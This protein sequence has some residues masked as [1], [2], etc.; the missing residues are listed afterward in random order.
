MKKRLL[1]YATSFF[2]GMSVM[3]VELSI[4]RLL[5]PYFGTSQIIWTVIIGLIMISLSIGNVIGGISADKHNSMNRLYTIIWAA[6]IWIAVI[7]F[8][9]KYIIVGVMGVLALFFPSNLLISG[10]ALSCLIL[11]SIPMIGLGM[12]SP[13]LVKL[14]VNDIENTGKTAGKI[15]AMNT[16]GSIIGTFLPT[17]VTIPYIGTHKTF[18]IFSLVLNFICLTYFVFVK[19]KIIRASGTTIIVFAILLLPVSNS[20]AFWTECVV[21]DES[22]YNYLQVTEDKDS[23]YLSTNV[24]FGVQSIY[25]KDNKLSGLYYDYALM[26]PQ[27]IRNFDSENKLDLLILGNGTG[28]YAKQS[29]MYY[30]NINTDAVEIDSKIVDLSKKYFSLREDEANIY[31][32]DGRTFLSDK[33]CGLYDVIMIDAYHDI[34]VPFHMATKEFFTEVSQHLKPEGVII[35]NINMKSTGDNPINQYLSQTVKSVMEKVY[36]CNLNN[37]TNVLLFA[38]NDNNMQSSFEQNI[39]KLASDNPLS[40]VSKYV[41]ANIKEVTEAKLIFTDDLA[42]VDVLGQSLLNEIVKDELKNF[43]D[44]VDFE[45][46]GFDGIFELLN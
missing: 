23:V 39:K 5:A 2:C 8:I 12:V 17:F 16:I 4:S 45:H 22:L 32:T 36:T 35:L 25:K 3:A 41:Q 30:P 26:A 38:S 1:L 7:P 33:K 19:S 34:T 18:L 13:Y 15:Y 9:G 37:S 11:F 40:E 43:K 46:K 20:Y 27:F 42:P 28:T 10:S 21:E 31:E 24:A 14:G 44:M 29:K 6:A